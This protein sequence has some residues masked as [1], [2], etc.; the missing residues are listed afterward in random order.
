MHSIIYWAYSKHFTFVNSFYRVIFYGRYYYPHLIDRETEA[1]KVKTLIKAT[2]LE[3]QNLNPES[4]NVL[5]LDLA[6]VLLHLSHTMLTPVS[7][8]SDILTIQFRNQRFM[9]FKKKVISFVFD[10]C[11][12]LTIHYS[13]TQLDSNYA[14][15]LATQT[16]N[17]IHNT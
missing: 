6:T 5:V 15:Y 14:L 13:G 8:L 4:L 1:W 17:W 11:Y 10:S 2:Q 9:W 12:L 3:S 16:L 7:F